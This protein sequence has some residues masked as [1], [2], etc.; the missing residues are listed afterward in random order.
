MKRLC[1]GDANLKASACVGARTGGW[2]ILFTWYRETQASSDHTYKS[3]PAFFSKNC[4]WRSDES[5]DKTLPKNVTAVLWPSSSTSRKSPV[6]LQS[7]DFRRWRPNSRHISRRYSWDYIWNS[8]SRKIL[9][10]CRLVLGSSHSRKILCSW[11]LALWTELVSVLLSL[12]KSETVW[13]Y[14][15]RS[16][17]NRHMQQALSLCCWCT[18]RCMW[19]SGFHHWRTDLTF[20]GGCL[21]WDNWCLIFDTIHLL[22]VFVSSYFV[23]SCVLLVTHLVSLSLF[24]F[25]TLF[26]LFWNRCYCFSSITCCSIEFCCWR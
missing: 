14:I 4:T 18:W 17:D 16:L 1:Y 19:S 2:T 23:H 12:I 11:R 10:S 8:H 22:L 5:V 21:L 24:P 7:F 26:L 13:R 3:D 20:W 9:C 25:S 6:W 15:C